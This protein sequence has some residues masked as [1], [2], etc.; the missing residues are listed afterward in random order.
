M[1][2]RLV[3]VAT[4]LALV[5]MPCVKV[6]AV[7]AKALPTSSDWLDKSGDSRIDAG[8]ETGVSEETATSDA[9]CTKRCKQWHA[10]VPRVEPLAAPLHQGKQ[11]TAI[12]RCQQNWPKSSVVLTGL[13]ARSPPPPNGTA[14][15]V[16][17][18][19]TSRFLS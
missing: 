3:I 2:D 15:Q 9:S 11:L 10:V 8:T 13:G 12:W 19:K 14:F 4:I 6:S 5:L 18:F 7:Y 1:R 16:A 17:Y